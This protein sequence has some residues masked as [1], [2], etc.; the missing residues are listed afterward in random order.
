MSK[1]TTEIRF[2]CE[3]SAGLQESAGFND[4]DNIIESAIPKIFNFDFPIYDESY[5]NVLCSKILKHYYTR[6]ICA[7]TVGLWKLWLSARLNEIMP[8]YNQLYKSA[9][10]EFNPMYDVDLTTTQKRDN[11]GVTNF[12]GSNDATSEQNGSTA[13]NDTSKNLYSETPQGSLDNVDNETYLTNATKL[14]NNGLTTV[15]NTNTF[16]GSNRSENNVK[17]TEEYL[18]KIQGKNGGASY[19][20]RLVEFRNTFINIDAMIIDELKDL[21]FGLW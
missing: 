13:T 7:E 3:V 11:T 18:Q 16:K 20:K 2:I 1:Y 10:I 6:E 19:S 8:Y 17:T 14:I 15:N 9:T 4:V 21:F 5:R 12:S